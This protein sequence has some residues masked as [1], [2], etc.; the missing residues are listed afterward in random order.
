MLRGKNL[1][2]KF[3]PVTTQHYQYCVGWPEQD[4]NDAFVC[5]IDTITTFPHVIET[6]I[7]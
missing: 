7:N 3:Y 6:N 2:M 5:V 1:E 4:I